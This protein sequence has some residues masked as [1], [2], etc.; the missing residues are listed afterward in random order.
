MI[1]KQ[2]ICVTGTNEVGRK[3]TGYKL[4]LFLLSRE[5]INFYFFIHSRDRVM[6]ELIY[7]FVDK[8]RGQLISN[9][10]VPMLTEWEE[11]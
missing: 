2:L 10:K 7:A 5:I 6:Y 1:K 3:A 11:Y 9:V 4:T 8:L